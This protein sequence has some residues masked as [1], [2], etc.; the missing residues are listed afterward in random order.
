MA[1]S[2]SKQS[3]EHVYNLVSGFVRECSINWNQIMEMNQN[4]HINQQNKN[5]IEL[6]ASKRIKLS[7]QCVINFIILSYVGKQD[8]KI[9][10]LDI[11]GVLNK[12]FDS[13][14]D[15]TPEIGLNKESILGLC[16]IINKTNCKIVLSSDWRLHEKDKNELFM[17]IRN[18]G[19]IDMEKDHIYIGDTPCIM[20][21]FF[22]AL[23][24]ESYLKNE[25]VNEIYNIISWCAVD[26]RNLINPLGASDKM[27]EKCFQ[28]MYNHFV[29]TKEEYGLTQKD[30]NY[31][32]A[33][34][35]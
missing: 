3:I 34:L 27:K 22:R 16:N 1:E 30:M 14:T 8:I 23:E 25:Y 9:L 5:D 10:F 18:K 32:I 15:N 24:I 2:A 13:E 17:E 29:R 7:R 19:Y 21:G 26:D 4:S 35:T 28:I 12:I 31:I 33:K 20:S 6:H 11:D